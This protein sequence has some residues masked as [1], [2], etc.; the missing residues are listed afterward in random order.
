[1][2]IFMI[3]MKTHRCKQTVCIVLLLAVLLFSSRFIASAAA[4]TGGVIEKDS[5]GIFTLVAENDMLR[6]TDQHFTHGTRLSYYSGRIRDDWLKRLAE[7]L[8]QFRKHQPPESWRANLALGQ[9]I[10]TPSDITVAELQPNERPWAGYLYLGLGIVRAERNAAGQPVLIDSFELQ[11]GVVGPLAM[12]GEV[13]TW[14]HANVSDSPRPMGWDHQLHNEPVINLYWDRQWRYLLLEG[15][16]TTADGLG[17]APGYWELDLIPHSG[18]ALGNANAHLGGGVTLR[19]G[20]GL[21]NDNGPPRIRPSL[22]GAGY[23]RKLP[24]WSGYLFVG[25][26]GRLVGRNIFLDGNTF[27]DSHSVDKRFLGFDAQYGLVLVYGGFK[28]AITNIVRAEEFRGQQ[29]ADRFTA[30][31][32]SWKL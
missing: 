22:P 19:F 10:Y 26:E 1:M 3:R 27:S 24:G 17:A 16:R 29:K 13:Q 6:G 25:G 8:P 4:E 32:F 12:A 20:T 14:W 28:L 30:F 11:L 2:K 18:L 31:S 23:F 7:L 15:V 5:P 9:N 21:K